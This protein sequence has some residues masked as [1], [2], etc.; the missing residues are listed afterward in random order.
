MA[1]NIKHLIKDF[2]ICVITEVLGASRNPI[3]ESYH[4]KVEIFQIMIIH[5][6]LDHFS[7]TFK[8]RFWI[9]VFNDSVLRHQSL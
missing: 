4:S 3:L 6:F 9:P 1:F 5:K 2:G 8:E 7:E